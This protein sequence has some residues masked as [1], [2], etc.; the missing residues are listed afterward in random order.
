MQKNSLHLLVA[1]LTQGEKMYFKKYGFP[2]TKKESLPLKIYALLEQDVTI[3]NESIAKRLRKTDLPKQTISKFLLYEEILASLYR[4]N[5][6]DLIYAKYIQRIMQTKL[7]F[8]KGLREEAALRLEKYIQQLSQYEQFDVLL[9]AW[10]ILKGFYRTDDR[11]A[12]LLDDCNKAIDQCLSLIANLQTCSSLLDFIYV[13]RAKKGTLTL[14]NIATTES[15]L[16]FTSHPFFEDDGLALSVSAKLS[17]FIAKAFYYATSQN[18]AME[19][20]YLEKMRMLYDSS[21]YYKSR[22]VFNYFV[23]MNQYLNLLNRTNQEQKFDEYYK[24]LQQEKPKLNANE[25]ARLFLIMSNLALLRVMGVPGNIGFSYD[26][27][28]MVKDIDKHKKY[29]SETSIRTLY[30]NFAITFFQLKEYKK[31]LVF[32]QKILL[33]LSDRNVSVHYKIAVTLLVMIELQGKDYTGV[34]LSL[35]KYFQVV[36]ED[37]YFEIMIQK[38][39]PIATSSSNKVRQQLF[40]EWQTELASETFPNSVKQIW[41]SVYLPKWVREKV[42]H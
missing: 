25:N 5:E 23:L 17:L 33:N 36:A 3:S 12:L 26:L 13:R 37:E 28:Q 29:T 11:K 32:V 39:D 35:K 34:M 4:Y 10:N 8:E 6:E 21:P 16:P 24:S 1:S 41:Y 2:G 38:I 9:I 27:N 30:A 40:S 19:S 31:S 15:W 18:T 42:I 20:V 22:N 14:G 7:L